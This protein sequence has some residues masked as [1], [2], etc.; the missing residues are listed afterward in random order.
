MPVPVVGRGAVAQIRRHCRIVLLSLVISACGRDRAD[1]EYFAALEGEET[2]MTREQQIAHLDAAILMSPRR[3]HY[4]E[5]RAVHWIDLQN[6]E[7]ARRDLDRDIELLDRPYARFLRGLA[8]CQA[9]EFGPSLADFDTAIARQPKNNQ[10]YRGRSLARAEVG[11]AVGAL[12]DAEHL[13]TTTPQQGESFYAR[14]V[15]RTLL[16][17]DREALADFDHALGI[18]PELVYVAEARVRAL[19]RIGDMEGARRGREV[20]DSLRNQNSGCA[21]C[22]DPFRY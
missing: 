16:G 21:A 10:F 17:R 7:R 11:D 22:L 3:A 6:F 14:G 5:T 1:R 18:R 15:A 19:E 13:V 8:A 20:V 2:G 9:G 4:Y 12:Q